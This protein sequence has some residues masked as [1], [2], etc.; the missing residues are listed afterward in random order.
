[1]K[2]IIILAEEYWFG[3]P[4]DPKYQ[5]AD[6]LLKRLEQNK[7]PR[8]NYIIL[9]NPGEL[10]STINKTSNIKAIFLFQDVISDCYLNNMNIARM[11]K[12][13]Y[14]LSN[15]GIFIY[16]PVNIIDTFGS[17]RYNKTLSDI[18]PYAALPKT[19]VLEI[20]NYLPENEDE[21]VNLLW[22]NTEEMYKEF[23][24]IVIKK[25]YSYEAKQVKTMN[26]SIVSNFEIF[27]ERAKGLNYKKFWNRGSNAMYLDKGADR[28]YIMQGFNKI[29]TKRE[30]E[31]RFFFHN[32]KLKFVAN[33]T[34]IPNI[35]IEDVKKNPL[36]YAMKKFAKKIFKDMMRA[37]WTLD[38]K[39]ILFRAD[40]SYAVDPQFQDKY[41]IKL[42]GFDSPIRIYANELEID[43]TNYFFNKT[44]CTADN[45]ITTET[46]QI[47]F[48][49]YINRFIK[50]LDD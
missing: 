32:G 12:Y 31:Y 34:G 45:S 24:K 37:I 28:Y 16:P 22:K 39:P 9:K 29:V 30:N 2:N 23:D 49:K 1:M 44:N 33:G 19:R 7:D 41:S 3:Y 40:V 35:C 20:K 4:E 42:E 46:L 8:F 13:L 47:N 15:K 6:V 21:V 18:F 14:D 43:P 26:K 50:S 48:A 17:K 25:G 36:M 38:R 5:P 10:V 11:K 27:K